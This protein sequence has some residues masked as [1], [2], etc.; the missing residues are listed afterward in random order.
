VAELLAVDQGTSATKAA[1]VDE[2]GEI[3]AQASAPVGMA[4]PR[5]GWA[6]QSADEIWD[7]VRAAVAECLSGRDPR[8]VAAVGLSTQRESLVLWDRR[9][10]EPLGPLLSWQDRRTADACAELRAQGAADE[11][12]ATSG[13][14]I[15][16][17]F[18]APKARWLLDAH[19]PGRE[20]SRR[21]ELCLGT[22]DSWLL[23]R[24]GGE[25]VI[26]A[27][28]AARTQ[29]LDVRRADWD[30]GLLELFGVPR[31]VLPR[32]VSS[33]G[34]FPSARGLAPLPD[35]TP[36]HAAMGDS[37]AALFA[38]A[39]WRP[40]QVKATYGTGTSVMC[41]GDA[42]AAAT[43]GV[44]LTIAWALGEGPVHALEA[45]IRATGAT[46]TWLARLLGTT[47]DELAA[48]AADSSDGVHVVPAFG[49]LGAPWW[50]DT[51]SGLVSGLTFG[52]GAPQLA[53][54][55][56][57]SIA[58]QI[59]DV[60]AAMDAGAGRIDTLL[61]DGGP[62]A[63]RTLMQLQADT[64]GRRVS[65]ALARDL[66]ALGAAHLAGLGAGV[67]DRAALEG[68][69]RPREDYEP[70]AGA[71]EREARLAAWHA[72]VARSRHHPHRPEEN[73]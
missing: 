59:E 30:D 49:G 19:D 11:V 56:L 20:R 3:V 70:A 61:A 54:A 57:E 5:P 15:D 66:S 27:G 64:S 72:A 29:L 2:R 68:L 52:S 4:H 26:E 32:V 48:L 69:A 63:N 50:D 22:I 25:H 7:S 9:T 47:P 12:F 10:G 45:N 39:G 41:V 37:H 28:N 24:F 21:G 65:R 31:E 6:G 43:G 23:S 62:T 1:L 38:H 73:R 14:P 16:P 18:S 55:A 34:P 36:V 58:F 53:R 46:L 33:H 40:G 51:A 42:A 8:T 13:L 67:W 71:A 44:C 17:M 35:G 60:V